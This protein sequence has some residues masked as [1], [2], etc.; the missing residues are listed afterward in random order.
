MRLQKKSKTAQ[1]FSCGSSS[2][3]GQS[4]DR[5]N[6]SDKR[7]EPSEQKNPKS[8]LTTIIKTTCRMN[9]KI[10]EIIPR[11][12]EALVNLFAVEFALWESSCSCPKTKPSF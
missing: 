5:E 11:T 3:K 1:V 10:I 8:S 4:D 7:Q 6:Q 9:L 12:L 2:A